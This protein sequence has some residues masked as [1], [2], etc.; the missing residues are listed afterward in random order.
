MEPGVSIDAGDRSEANGRRVTFGRLVVDFDSYRVSVGETRIELSYQEF[1]LLRLLLGEIGRII[2][3]QT[4]AQDL[5][6]ESGHAA[7]RHL[8]VIVHRLRTKLGDT[9]PYQLKTV[10]GRGYG[11]LV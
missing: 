11:M 10:R 3:Y 2:A 7:I 4:L 5:W 9:S 1:E 8:N 6:G